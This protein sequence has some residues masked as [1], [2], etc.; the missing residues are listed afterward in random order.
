[1]SSDLLE[2]VID[3]R[4]DRGHT[5]RLTMPADSL[6]RYLVAGPDLELEH[7]GTRYYVVELEDVRRD[8]EVWTT[9]E[10][11]ARWYRLGDEAQPG[12]V[13]VDDATP[14][15]GLATILE[16][17]T[18]TVGT[19][20]SSA[21]ATYSIA[22]D[23]RS[24]LELLRTWAKVTG[25]FLVFDT[26]NSTVDI[27]DDRGVDSGLALRYGRNIRGLRRRA[28]P[29]EATR[30][31][32][33]GDNELTIAGQAGGVEYVED[34]SYYTAKG[35]SE[36]DARTLYG[37][38]R[39]WVDTSFVDDRELYEA[40]VARLADLA[41]EQVSYEVQA[42]NLGE[43]DAE[44]AIAVGDTVRVQD[45]DIAVDDAGTL[46][47]LRGTIV[48][49]VTYPLEPWRNEV[50][51]AFQL[52]A[53]DDP[54][55]SN[56]RGDVGRE[57]RMFTGPVGSDY[58]LRNDAR[59]S[60]ARIPLRFTD[61]RAH[62][63]LDMDLVGVGAGDVE[64]VVY[65]NER[66][67]A[68]RTR[69]AAYSD[70]ATARFQATWAE[71]DVAGLRD[72][73]IRVRATSSGGSS[74]ASGA[75]L[76]ADP[77]GEARFYVLAQG[78]VRE[79][80]AAANS[81]RFDYVSDALQ[82]FTVPDGVELV[83]VK[84][85]GAGGGS[86]E[87]GTGG[88]GGYVEFK[89][90]VVPGSTIDV[91]APSGGGEDESPGARTRGWG[92]G[93]GNGNGGKGC[94]GSADSGGGGGGAAWIVADGGTLVDAYG[95]AAGG[96]GGNGWNSNRATGGAGGFPAGLE[97]TY[98]AT[99]AWQTAQGG[100]QTAGGVGENGS[101][102]ANDPAPS[103]S[104]GQGAD[105]QDSGNSFRSGG[106]GGGG[107]WYGG[108]AG[109]MPSGGATDGGGGGGGGSSYIDTTTA[110]DITFTTGGGA[111]GGTIADGPGEN[112]YVIFEWDDPVA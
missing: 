20:S 71:E 98:A 85:A 40:A 51:I 77:T 90:D 97:A 52:P 19:S 80:P 112:G 36:A 73:R 72:Y 15:A 70:G 75:D 10:L 60:V 12:T 31:Y 48:R 57:W 84:L 26:I 89:L 18:W 21:T 27:V 64:L 100:T 94:N 30:L 109:L 65:D 86:G 49:T 41:V 2:F 108:G 55:A 23:D 38:S 43:Y 54:A 8:G 37:R 101:P 61:G 47:D 56:T 92:G 63:H 39:V 87:T 50:E 11:E 91:Y 35:L 88:A 62:W 66:D 7:D 83:T 103:G 17:S 81:E 110:F 9:V 46:L 104:F 5:A 28:R 106:G 34:L 16:R 45:P 74:L 33:Y 6:K 29:P 53:L 3:E 107:G 76:A 44:S 68:V 96:G 95:V 82:E 102:D 32:A 58:E 105:G 78:A 67:Q 4:L 22:E 42:A 99:R 69:V 13:T 79:A 14:A 1:M 59:W 111:A 93:S 25:R 24:T